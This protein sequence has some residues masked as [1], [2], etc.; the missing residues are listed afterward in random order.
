MDIIFKRRFQT[1]F[2]QDRVDMKRCTFEVNPNDCT[3]EVTLISDVSI[4][5]A[6]S[7]KHIDLYKLEGSKLER[8]N[9]KP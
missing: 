6:S 5:I 7:C 8:P 3:H 9:L 1:F 4:Y 2:L